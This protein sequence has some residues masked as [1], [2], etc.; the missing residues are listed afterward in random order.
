M[1]DMRWRDHILYILYLSKIRQFCNGF[2][3]IDAPLFV[4]ILDQFLQVKRQINH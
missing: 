1:N 4:M 2:F 3:I